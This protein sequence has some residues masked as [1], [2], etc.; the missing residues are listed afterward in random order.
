MPTAVQASRLDR[1]REK[2][3]A[4]DGSLGAGLPPEY[5]AEENRAAISLLES[6]IGEVSAEEVLDR[7]FGEFCIGK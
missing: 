3:L 4:L 1:V 5:L 7:V 6:V 2:L